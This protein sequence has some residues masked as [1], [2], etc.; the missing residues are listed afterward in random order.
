MTRKVF[1][2]VATFLL[3]ASDGFCRTESIKFTSI[4]F[5]NA[6]VDDL[7][8]RDSGGMLLH[9]LQKLRR[10]VLREHGVRL[11]VLRTERCND[12]ASQWTD[13]RLLG[14]MGRLHAERQR[15]LLSGGVRHG[16]LKLQAVQ[17][18]GG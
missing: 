15:L 9:K 17:A 14:E 7:E 5:E 13:R 11:P 18:S 8:G 1:V 10:H 4:L 12:L 3:S 16:K 2:V 6:L